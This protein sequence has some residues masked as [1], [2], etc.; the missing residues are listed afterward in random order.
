MEKKIKIALLISLLSILI[1]IFLGFSRLIPIKSAISVLISSGI[2]LINFLLFS[3]SVIFSAN[4][5]N[6]IF[7][8]LV[9]GG[10][11]G[12][13]FLV[14]LLVFLT[15]FYLKVDQYAFIFGLLIW[16]V[17]L[18]IFEIGIVKDSLIKR[19]N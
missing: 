7:L 5:S 10:I 9:L 12:R 3:F 16:Y 18:L 6:K 8:K 4:K 13:M 1:L 17:F 11:V 2:S 14:L 15:L 19:K